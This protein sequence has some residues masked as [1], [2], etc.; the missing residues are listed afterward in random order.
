MKN[1]RNRVSGH[2]AG[3]HQRK[4]SSAG[5]GADSVDALLAFLRERNLVP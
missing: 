5:S 3:F 4:R 2:A 1:F